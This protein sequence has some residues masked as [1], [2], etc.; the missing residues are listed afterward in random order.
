[1]LPEIT[2]ADENTKNTHMR[3]ALAI[4]RGYVAGVRANGTTTGSALW[5]ELL[6]CDGQCRHAL[7][8]TWG[9]VHST[10]STKAIFFDLYKSQPEARAA[11]AI[12]T[13]AKKY[14]VAPTTLNRLLVWA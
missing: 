5:A 14:G 13:A 11:P 8:R 2:Q 7:A 10:E 1:M 4:A 12:D 6:Q 9:L 3:D